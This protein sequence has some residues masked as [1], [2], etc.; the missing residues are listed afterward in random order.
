MKDGFTDESRSSFWYEGNFYE[1]ILTIDEEPDFDDEEKKII[2]FTDNKHDENGDLNMYINRLYIEGGTIDLVEIEDPQEYADAESVLD[3]FE[4][5]LREG[6]T[7]EEARDRAQEFLDSTALGQGNKEKKKSPPPLMSDSSF[8]NID[9]LF[10][11]TL[12][13]HK[14]P[15][16]HIDDTV[17]DDCD[18]DE[19]FSPKQALHGISVR[20]LIRNRCDDSAEYHIQIRSLGSAYAPSL[21][22]TLSKVYSGIGRH[23]W[24][25]GVLNNLP[26]IINCR[27]R[28]VLEAIAKV[29]EDVGGE[30]AEIS[31]DKYYAAAD[32]FD[33]SEEN[34]GIFE[35]AT[36]AFL[37]ANKALCNFY[38][39]H[40]SITASAN[41][42]QTARKLTEVIPDWDMYTL[43][44]VLRDMLPYTIHCENHAQ[45]V[46]AV[47]VIERNGGKAELESDDTN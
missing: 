6:K 22:Q 9:D 14:D 29:I 25:E 35:G 5:L 30:T 4:Q 43:R 3:R 46:M 40:I 16:L 21:A 12:S 20:Q 37:K 45:A 23:A 1:T 7:P 33:M 36:Q 8:C 39:Q 42:A 11:Y 32:L 26:Y 28:S 24:S 47:E 31:D 41:Y 34:N 27:S 15:T 10:Y 13:I 18:E 17:A 19:M 44:R 2:I 38:R